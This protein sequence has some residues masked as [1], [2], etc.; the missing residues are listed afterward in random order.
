MKKLIL[1]AAASVLCA[2]TASAA[3]LSAADRAGLQSAMAQHIDRQLVEGAYMDVDLT[4][5]DVRKLVPAKNHPM[6]L[7]M[8][9][10]FVLCTD[11]KTKAGESVNV[12]FYVARRGKAFVIFRSEIA[13]RAP[14]EALMAAG[15]VSMID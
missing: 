5:G 2:F 1:A 4:S 3:P 14:L 11:F 10:S 15:K 8:G 9:D 13:N 12:D 6:V 7:Q